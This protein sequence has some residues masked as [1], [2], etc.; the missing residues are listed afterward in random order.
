V[1]AILQRKPSTDQGT[2][3][4]LTFGA[5][6]LR[7]LELPWRDNRRQRSCIPP[8][9]YE[10][11]IVRSPR[12]GRVYGVHDVPGRSHVLIHAA[13]LAGDAELGWTTELQGCIAPFRTLGLMR[14]N[15][16]AMQAAGL[17]SRPALGELMTW[18]GGKPFELEI[19]C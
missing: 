19:Q 7:A 10:C 13:N 1:K 8:G 9:T 16:G 2:F 12:F 18:A 14:N 17:V 11:A 15:A 4:V 5:H 6:V 3:S